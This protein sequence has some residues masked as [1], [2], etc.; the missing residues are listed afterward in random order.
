[1][2]HS[3]T[4]YKKP[5][6]AIKFRKKSIEIRLNDTKRRRVKTGDTIHFEKLPDRKES[7]EVKV[8][9]LHSFRTFEEMFQ[10]LPS[11]AL[12]C[13]GWSVEEMLESIYKIYTPQQEQKWGA[14]AISFQV[15][16]K[17]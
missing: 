11:E 6:A 17:D 15:I 1:M 9:D 5:F 3:M 13:K 2:V 16:G 7:I 14:L 10:A 12:D 8:E 4:L